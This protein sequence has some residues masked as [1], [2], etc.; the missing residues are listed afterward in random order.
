M[1]ANYEVSVTPCTESERTPSSGVAE[2]LLHETAGRESGYEDLVI[3]VAAEDQARATRA[4][5]I[6]AIRTVDWE[7]TAAASHILAS[8]CRVSS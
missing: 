2:T 7:S 6:D 5:G 3:V 8:R 4:D 1:Q